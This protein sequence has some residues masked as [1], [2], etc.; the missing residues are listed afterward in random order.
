MI[1]CFLLF[2]RATRVSLT[3]KPSR[4]R[5]FI[6]QFAARISQLNAQRDLALSVRRATQTWIVRPHDGRDSVQHPFL[7]FISINEP[8]S[9]LLNATANSKIVVT[10]RDDHVRP[11]D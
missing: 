4:S 9:N 6:P 10:R 1:A 7:Q 3:L 11:G 5:D 8:L 2:H